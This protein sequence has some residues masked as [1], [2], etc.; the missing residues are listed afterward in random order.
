MTDPDIVAYVRN[1][2]DVGDAMENSLH[3]LLRLLPTD[4]PV[5]NRARAT[6]HRY[7]GLKLE[8]LTPLEV[9]AS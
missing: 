6:L 4:T 1:L 8:G 5:I 9:S 7:Q 3:E 2:E